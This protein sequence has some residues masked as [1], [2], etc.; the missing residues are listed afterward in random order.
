MVVGNLTIDDIVLPDGTTRMA[1]V[2]GNS[3]YAALGARPWQPSIGVVT[4]RGDDFPGDLA[5]E[6]ASLG[7]A[8]MW[9]T[10]A[11]RAE[12]QA[13]GRSSAWTAISS[14]RSRGVR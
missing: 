9:T 12:S 6:L 4:R 3:L 8:A 10:G 1:S 5:Q 2:G 11:G 7:I 14:E 13:S